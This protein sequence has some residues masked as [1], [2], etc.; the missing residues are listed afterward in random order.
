MVEQGLKSGHVVNL[1]ELG[2]FYLS[3]RSECVDTPGDFSVRKHVKGVVCRMSL[4]YGSFVFKS[5]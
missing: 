4:L 2:K 3:I 1:G 5:V